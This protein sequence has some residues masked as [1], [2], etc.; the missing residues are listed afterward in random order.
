MILDKNLLYRL[1]HSE[2]NLL[3][4]TKLMEVLTETKT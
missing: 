4:D 3:E 2:G 1:I